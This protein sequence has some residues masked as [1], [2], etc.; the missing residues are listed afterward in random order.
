VKGVEVSRRRLPLFVSAA[1]FVALA[2]TR[3]VRTL[4]SQIAS[5][6]RS[7]FQLTLAIDIIGL[8]LTLV[9]VSALAFVDAPSAGR[10]RRLREASPDLPACTVRWTKPLAAD[11]V[12]VHA[13]SEEQVRHLFALT[14]TLSADRDGVVFWAGLFRPRKLA[15]IPWSSIASI[16]SLK[17]QPGSRGLQIS[18]DG[19]LPPIRVPSLLHGKSN[20]D[21]LR[22][23]QELLHAAEG[24]VS[25]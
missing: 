11:L 22:Q 7:V 15:E 21:I 5:G 24:H 16:D 13:V 14:V 1:V 17:S 3:A 8:C 20:P 19:G 10:L 23:L 12:A 2:T 4:S 18:L 6:D 25:T 9:L